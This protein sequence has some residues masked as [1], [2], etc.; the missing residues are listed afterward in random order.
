MD[1]KR[2]S[3]SLFFHSI[4]FCGFFTA[5]SKTHCNFL[6]ENVM[7]LNHHR[8]NKLETNQNPTQTKNLNLFLSKSKTYLI[9]NSMQNPFFNEPTAKLNCNFCYLK[10]IFKYSNLKLTARYLIRVPDTKMRTCLFDKGV[11]LSVRLSEGE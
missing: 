4:Q 6:F 5:D 8:Q 10:L 1:Q 2:T 7:N 3:L 9:K 11:Q